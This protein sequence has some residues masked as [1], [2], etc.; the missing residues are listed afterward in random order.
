VEE[1]CAFVLGAQDASRVAKWYALVVG[2]VA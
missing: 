1:S 2:Q